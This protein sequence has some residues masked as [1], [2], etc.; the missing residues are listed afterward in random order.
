MPT[1]EPELL[2]DEQIMEMARQHLLALKESLEMLA[3]RGWA[4]YLS[5]GRG[6]AELVITGTMTL[7]ATKECK[8]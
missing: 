3:S 5:N 8:L 4:P 2:T 6:S 1:P 7:R